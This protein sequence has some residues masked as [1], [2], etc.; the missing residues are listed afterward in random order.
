MVELICRCAPEVDPGSFRVVPH[1][2][3]HEWFRAGQ[4][5]AAPAWAAQLDPRPNVARILLVGHYNYHR[6]FET[7]LRA[8]GR[9]RRTLAR[10]V[11]LVLTTRLGIG[12]K[13]RRYDTTA[14]ACLM[15]S[16]NLH[17]CVAMLGSVPPG[18]MAALYRAADVVVCPSYAESF[19][20]PMVEA[21]AAGKPI[22][23]S[24]L[25]PHREVCGDA[26]VYF[27]VFDPQ[28]LAEQLHRLLDDP[29]LAGQLAEN[30]RRRSQQFCWRKHFGELVGL[31]DEA[32]GAIPAPQSAEAA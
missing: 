11:E 8:I 31:I 21:M 7:V 9:L 12:V 23:A 24:D 20:H 19:G 4:S 15:V 18:E 16:G 17:R 25:P 26:A 3:D 5:I 22:V 10:P 2:F 13:D 27:P 1:G 30:G 29:S 14:A 28:V 6:N 32:I